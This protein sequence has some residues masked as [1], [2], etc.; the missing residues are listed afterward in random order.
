MKQMQAP[1]SVEILGSGLAGWLHNLEEH[2]ILPIM[3]RHGLSESE[4]D[5]EGWYP[6]SLI[7][8]MQRVLYARDGGPQLLTAIGKGT[9]DAIVPAMNPENIEDAL[10]NNTDIPNDM[11]YGFIWQ[12]IN[13]AKQSSER[14]VLKPVS[15]YYPNSEEGAVFELEWR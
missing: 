5:P 7:N 2:E 8:E 6:M 14:F 11:V 15:G 12:A 10:H 3:E 1:E 4:V 9:A 13:L